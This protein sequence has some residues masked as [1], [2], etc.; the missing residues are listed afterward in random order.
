LLPTFEPCPN[1]W[2]VLPQLTAKPASAFAPSTQGNALT[3]RFSNLKVGV[4][5][6]LSNG[7]VR[8]AKL[9]G[10]SSFGLLWN[11]TSFT[12]YIYEKDLFL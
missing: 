11:M 5:K 1:S 9:R 12:S 2:Q 8:A 10:E 7:R 3:L 6:Y 4:T